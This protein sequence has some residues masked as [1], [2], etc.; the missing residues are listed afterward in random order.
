MRDHDFVR[1]ARFTAFGGLVAGPLMVTWY[2]P[3]P[4]ENLSW[5]SFG[6]RL[7]QGIVFLSDMSV[8]RIQI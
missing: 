4:R 2:V 5:G 3:L 6:L 8:L 1:M 7:I